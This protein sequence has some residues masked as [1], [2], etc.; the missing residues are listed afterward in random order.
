LGR[1]L[2]QVLLGTGGSEK[3]FDEVVDKC[4]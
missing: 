1:N 3:Q 2:L 4:W